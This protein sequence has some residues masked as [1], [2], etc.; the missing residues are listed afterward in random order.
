MSLRE[1]YLSAC[2]PKTTVW[3]YIR[4]QEVL[5]IHEINNVECDLDPCLDCFDLLAVLGVVACE[6][7]LSGSELGVESTF[8]RSSSGD[9]G[10]LESAYTSGKLRGTYQEVLEDSVCLGVGEELGETNKGSLHDDI[11]DVRV[12]GEESVGDGDGGKVV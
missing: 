6:D 9:V 4:L 11:S 2:V 7:N 10:D 12:L 8:G 5:P 3:T 1:T